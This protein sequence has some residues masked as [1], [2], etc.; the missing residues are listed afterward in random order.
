M[1]QPGLFGGND[2]VARTTRRLV[3]S[4]AIPDGIP[5]AVTLQLFGG[6]LGAPP[7]VTVALDVLRAD[8]EQLWRWFCDVARD[9]HR[10]GVSPCQQAVDA[11]GLPARGCEP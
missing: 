3:A 7:L 1:A 9:W 4:L 2:M 11:L 10:H 5:D 6:E 8:G